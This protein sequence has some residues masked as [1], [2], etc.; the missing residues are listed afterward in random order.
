MGFPPGLLP[1]LV[2]E[3][4]RTDAPYSP[5][6]PLDIEK[7]ALPPPTPPDAYLAARLEKFHAELRVRP[8][9]AMTSPVFLGGKAWYAACGSRCT[10]CPAPLLGVLQ[11][12]VY[13][14]SS[15]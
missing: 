3:K 7:A 11:A 10:H 6:S 13:G 4:L 8:L 15:C 9:A 14:K 12:A 2:R 5:L 1:E